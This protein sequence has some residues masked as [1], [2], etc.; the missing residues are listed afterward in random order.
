MAEPHASSDTSKPVPPKDGSEAKAA[1]AA[2]TRAGE[3]PSGAEPRSFTDAGRPAGAQAQAAEAGRHAG[4]SVAEAWGRSLDPFMAFQYD[5]NRWFDDVWRQMTGLPMQS[6]LRTARPMASMGA[7]SLFGLPAADLRETNQA[8]ELALELPGVTREDIDISLAHDALTVVGHKAEET[9]EGAGA[10]RVS[11]R[12]YGHFER[13]FPL[14]EDIDRAAIKAAFRDG[15]LH[16]TLPKTRE[17]AAHR[18]RIEID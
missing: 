12:R 17:A 6:P 16:V 7:A 3:N 2:L 15:V 13:S 11:E 18:S 9:Q 4:R 5:M 1:A 10:Y 14:P 8:Y